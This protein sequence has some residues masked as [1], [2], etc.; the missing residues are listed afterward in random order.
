MGLDFLVGLPE[1]VLLAGGCAL[2]LADLYVKDIDRRV[3]Y[4]IAQAVLLVTAA[5]T[6][7]V[8]LGSGGNL[9]YA[10]GKLYVADF[11]AHILKLTAYGAVSLALVYS[12]Q[13]LADRDLMTGEFLPLLLFALLG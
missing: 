7:F 8:L 11:M 6:V 10:F 5:A 9:L 3:S 1:I 13:Y 12:R 4:A 2:M